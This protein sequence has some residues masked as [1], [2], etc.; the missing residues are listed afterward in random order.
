MCFRRNAAASETSAGLLVTGGVNGYST[1]TG[2]N[3]LNS[4]LLF[5]TT[6]QDFTE[7]P[8][9]TY[10][11]CQVTV[12]D[13]VYIVGG[14]TGRQ[15]YSDVIGDT[16]KLT[17]SNQW[18][19]LSSLN[20]PRD[21]HACV[22]WDGGI[23]AI[24]GWRYGGLSSVEWYNIVSNKWFAFTQ[25]PVELYG[26]QAVVW[27]GDLYLLGGLS[28]NGG[29]NNKVVYKLKKGSQTWEV[30]PGVSLDLTRYRPIFPAVITDNI[31][32]N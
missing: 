2:Y 8:V 20:I 21:F 1:L 10:D 27:E 16:Y 11:H 14:D 30:V 15:D 19:K 22:E 9:A 17:S 7:S 13:T 23:L 6:W 5:T 26:H 4:T 24:G 31:H 29:D 25:I 28:G 3:I 12:G 32:C 18:S